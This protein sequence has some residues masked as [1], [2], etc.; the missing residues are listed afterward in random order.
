MCIRIA[1][2]Q[3]HI[4]N[5]SCPNTRPITTQTTHQEILN[6]IDVPWVTTVYVAKETVADHNHH[7]TN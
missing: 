4:I 6:M 1:L 3:L 5:Q 7:T 2:Y